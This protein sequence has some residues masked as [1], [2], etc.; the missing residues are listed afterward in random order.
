MTK[1]KTRFPRNRD[2]WGCP[3]TSREQ[4]GQAAPRPTQEICIP[5]AGCRLPTP[6][7][8]YALRQKVQISVPFFCA[9]I[10][11]LDKVFAGAGKKWYFIIFSL[12][13]CLGC[14]RH[15]PCFVG[16]TGPRPGGTPFLDP[17]LAASSEMLKTAFQT[18]T[19]LCRGG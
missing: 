6:M 14:A 11:P 3:V 16:P 12:R 13:I 1:T 8:I 5:W 9:C 2:F 19:M 4:L 10:K 17:K 7:N 15:G 18:L